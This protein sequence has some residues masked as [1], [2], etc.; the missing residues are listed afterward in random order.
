MKSK[1]ILLGI[2][3]SLLFACQN[4]PQATESKPQVLVQSNEIEDEKAAQLVSKMMTAMGGAEKWEA[5]NYVSWTFFGAR[6]LVWDKKNNR[7]RIESPRDSSV[8]LVDLNDSIGKYAYDGQEVLDPKIRV[9]KNK[10]GK[11]IWRNDMYWLFMPFKLYDEGVAVK[12]LRLDTISKDVPADVLE[13]RFDQVGDTPEN[14]YEIYIDQKDQLIKRW[15]FFEEASQEEPY[16]SWPWDNYSN[17]NGLLLSFSRS[18]NSGPSNVQVYEHL[19]DKVFTSFE[20][21][22]FYE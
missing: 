15:T 5:L 14:K 1:I 9:E 8:Y 13:L 17:L 6:H 2:F 16:N 18:D 3:T 10:R 21:F 4:P 7:V 19:D 20:A 22:K 12:Y 11:S